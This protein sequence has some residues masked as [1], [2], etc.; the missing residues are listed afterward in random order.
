MYCQASGLARSRTCWWRQ[1]CG[2]RPPSLWESSGRAHDP[3]RVLA[4]DVGVQVDHLRL[5]PQPELHAVA[6]DGVDQRREALG[7]Q[8]LVD[9]PVAQ[10][11]VIVAAAAE[12]AVVED[13]AFHAEPGGRF[14]EF[15]QGLEAV[16]EVDRLPG[17]EH[18][19]ARRRAGG[20]VHVVR[21]GTEPVVEGLGDA[22]QA[23]AGVGGEER[24]RPVA[25]A[26]A[27]HHFGRSR[28]ARRRRSCAG[29]PRGC[30]GTA[31]GC[32]SSPGAWPRPGL[33]VGEAG[34]PGGHQQRGVVAGAAVPAGADPGALLDGVPLR[35]VFAAPAPGEVEQF[36]A[37]RGTGSTVASSSSW[38]SA[39]PLLVSGV[40]SSSRPPGCR[41]SSEL[42]L[43]SGVGIPAG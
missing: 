27:Q 9:V 5:H 11:G 20:G 2:S 21:P 22:V 42:T 26:G 16:V 23:A 13:E 29:R 1:A 18:H 25:A 33:A 10:A 8:A 6:G 39:V 7:P 38:Y 40:A 32:R 43:E 3:V 34:G 28:A 30:R 31:R 15:E 36:V 12:P 17:V 41:V 4:G 35:V 14:G 24:R 37:S 19:R